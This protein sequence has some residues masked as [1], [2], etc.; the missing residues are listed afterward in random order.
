VRA[1]VLRRAL[2][3]TLTGLVFGLLGTAAAA[4]ALGAFLVDV[5][6][7]DPRVALGAAGLFTAVALLASWLPARRAASVDPVRALRWE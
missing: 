6:P 1:L 5:A 3:L 4:R 7:S 2:A